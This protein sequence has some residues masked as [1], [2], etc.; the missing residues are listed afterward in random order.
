MKNEP[1]VLIVRIWKI[2]KGEKG[3][4]VFHNFGELA[5]SD[6]MS[7]TKCKTVISKLQYINYC[8]L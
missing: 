4:S 2:V 5:D 7:T 8:N 6:M 3:G 1:V